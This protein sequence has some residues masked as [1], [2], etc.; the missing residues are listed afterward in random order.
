MSN[1]D[2]MNMDNLS[3]AARWL[4]PT[5]HMRT[6][7]LGIGDIHSGLARTVWEIGMDYALE[8]KRP[9]NVMF[10]SDG[11]DLMEGLATFNALRDV[12]DAGCELRGFVRG[13]CFS[14]ASYILQ[15]CDVRTAS[16]TS[17]IMVH[18]ITQRQVSFDEE[19]AERNIQLLRHLRG[20]LATEYAR[21]SPLSFDHWDKLLQ[22]NTPTFYTPAE[23]LA[24]GLV[25][26]VQ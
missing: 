14:A 10:T 19:N 26:V 18:G 7:T 23:A 4:T 22:S 13:N 24:A 20:T 6:R 5:A 3:Q 17:I 25:D 15:A 8:A 1:Y 21:R 2:A 12:H 16:P 11:G 9:V